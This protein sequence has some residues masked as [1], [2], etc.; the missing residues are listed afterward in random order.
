MCII[1]SV[2]GLDCVCK[3]SGVH[4]CCVYVCMSVCIRV[5]V[6]VYVY[7]AWTA[8][9]KTVVHMSVCMCAYVCIYARVYVGVCMFTWPGPLLQ[10]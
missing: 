7:V 2:R 8:F 4:L 5:Y 9:A 10:R 6:Y 3:D 1:C